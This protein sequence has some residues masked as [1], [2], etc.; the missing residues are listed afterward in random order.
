M[1]T[2]ALYVFDGEIILLQML[3]VIQR[4]AHPCAPSKWRPREEEEFY[5]GRWRSIEGCYCIFASYHVW[6]GYKEPESIGIV[7]V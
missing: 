7:G 1:A 3:T 6:P 4:F 5:C 2:K